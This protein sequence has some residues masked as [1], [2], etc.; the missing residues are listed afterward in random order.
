[1][2]GFR[3]RMM[4]ANANSSY[5]S[6]G[7]DFD[8]STQYAILAQALT[9]VQQVVFSVWFR[10]DGGDNALQVVFTNTDTDI[11]SR[12]KISRN[13]S[14]KLVVVIKNTTGGTVMSWTSASDVVAGPTWRH[15]LG[16]AN[17]QTGAGSIYLDD[18]I[19]GTPTL[20]PGGIYNIDWNYLAKPFA[21]GAFNTGTPSGYFDGCLSEVFI[22]MAYLDFTV[23]ANRRK[24]ISDTG[25][26]VDL[27]DTGTIPYGV[28]PIIYL[29]NGDPADNVGTLGNFTVVNGPLSASSTS[30]SD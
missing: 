23:E 18:A 8:G 20:G 1:M 11:A 14:N 2:L 25:K 26:P 4:A 12:V 19:D 30:P 17:S 27:G 15:I 22:G 7:R 13:A 29:P 9:D 5:V 16:S 24:F 3:A 6:S 10:L 21:V 28:Q